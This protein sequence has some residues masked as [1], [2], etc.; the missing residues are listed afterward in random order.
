MVITKIFYLKEK[1][2]LMAIKT[3]SKAIGLLLG[4]LL[5]LSLILTPLSVQASSEKSDKKAKDGVFIHLSHGS[6][7]PHRVL[8]ALKMASL[9]I[10]DKDVLVYIDIKGVEV[11]LKDSKDLKCG[12]FPSSHTQ[13]KELM[14][15][16]VQVYV[17]PACLEAAGKKPEDL[18]EGVKMADKNAF[19]NFTKGRILTLDY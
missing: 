16:K 8:M 17:C 14:A 13:L 5:V 12:Q 1:E 18:M 4:A 15:K 10:E 19:F 6:D 3:G 11:V 2:G 7:D 9:M